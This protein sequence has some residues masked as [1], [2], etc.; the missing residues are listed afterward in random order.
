[1]VVAIFATTELVVGK[2]ARSW[3]QMGA[4]TL[5]YLGAPP[6]NHIFLYLTVPMANA[7]QMLSVAA[8]VLSFLSV[9][10]N[11]AAYS[12]GRHLFC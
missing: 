9:N 3:I 8:V 1:M 12:S 6:H 4:P 5:E 7:F 10:V 2:A 11:A